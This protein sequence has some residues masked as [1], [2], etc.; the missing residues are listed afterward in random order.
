MLTTK[1][2]IATP[3]RDRF[4]G[5]I[6]LPGDHDWDTARATFN[7][8]VDQN[9]EVVAR[10]RN[11]AEAA[12]I[13]A[14]ARDAGLKIAPQGSGHNAR[15]LGSLEGT[16]VIRLDR[17]PGVSVDAEDQIARVEAGAR[18]WDIVPLAAEHGLSA[19][20]GSSPE[21]N[22]VGYT[23]GG[24]MGWQARKRGLQANS[25]TAVE[26]ITADGQERR[27]DADNEPEL[28]WALRGG[29]G[30]F[31]LVTAIE[32]RLYPLKD[33]YA[34]SFFFDYERSGE[35]FHAWREWTKQVPEEVTT[36]VRMLQFPPLEEVPEVVRGKSFAVVG[37]ALLTDEDDGFEL[38]RPLRALGAQMDTFGMVPAPALTELHMDPVEPVPYESASAMLGD[39]PAKA[40]DDLVEAV[41]PGTNSMLTGVELRHAG[42]ALS[43]EPVGAGAMSKLRSDYL[44]FAFGA[45]PA[46]EL[47]PV[48]QGQLEAVKLA[49]AEYDSGDRYFNFAEER[50][51]VE[52]LYPEGAVE[53]LRKIRAEY[54]PD[55][56]FR[57]NHAL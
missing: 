18:W 26:L 3:L 22:V 28:F 53:R 52:T 24:G 44:G 36:A 33:V 9:P 43:R 8:L 45:V 4:P 23:L 38:T 57:A 13:V 25:V 48:I 40:I 14:A 39:L 12:Q 15:P 55:G 2:N 49:F 56:L 47:Q 35:I 7:P 20:H 19:L 5:A 27:V 21:I 11:A 31:G 50:V 46:P 42:G 41:G 54:D 37:A 30:N 16:M 17:M 34:G 32:F 1:S 51:D 6:T 29:G 10:P